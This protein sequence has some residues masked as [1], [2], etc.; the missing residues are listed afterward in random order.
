M[1]QRMKRRILSVLPFLAAL[2]LAPSASAYLTDTDSRD[3]PF[4]VGGNTISVLEEYDPPSPGQ[5]GKKDPR[6]RN[7]GTADCYVRA[8]VVLTDSRAEEYILYLTDGKEGFSP[9]WRDGQ[10]GWL[11]YE[12]VLP[13][14]ESS[15]PVFTGLTWKE[16]MPEEI[17]ELSVDVLF[18][19][20]QSSGYDSPQ[21]AFASVAAG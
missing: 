21:E 5:T 12:N 17:P 10:D 6:V 18:E 4:T 3:N 9:A 15:A 7:E 13:P 14:G 16:G 19:S 1:R 2:L 20:V 8:R 11:Y